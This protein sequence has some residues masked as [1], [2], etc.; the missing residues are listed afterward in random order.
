M[1]KFNQ[2][3]YDKYKKDPKYILLNRDVYHYLYE[4]DEVNDTQLINMNFDYSDI[5][6]VVLTDNIYFNETDMKNY[7]RNQKI[8]SL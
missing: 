3:Y 6:L 4:R 1:I 2:I 8:N 5:N 7:Y